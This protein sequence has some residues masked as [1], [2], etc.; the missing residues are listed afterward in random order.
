MEPGVIMEAE[1]P[2]VRVGATP[3]GLTTPPQPPHV[4]Y[5]PEAL[6]AAQPGRAKRQEGHPH[7]NVTNFD[8]MLQTNNYCSIVH[9][10][11][12]KY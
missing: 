6:P 9:V 5:R 8:K 10:S 4:F 12:K 7:Y 1:E 11:V 2:A 3:A